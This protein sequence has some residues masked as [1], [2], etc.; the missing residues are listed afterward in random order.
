MNDKLYSMRVVLL[1]LIVLVFTASLNARAGEDY[2]LKGPHL[3]DV[4]QFKD[5]ARDSSQG[6]RLVPFKLHIPGKG[7]PYPVVVI[8]HGAGGNWDTHFAQAQ[9]LASHGFAVFCLEHVGSNTERMKRG[10]RIFH[11]LKQMIHSADEVLGRPKDVS[12][13]L[14]QITEWNKAH[15]SLKGRLDLGHVGVL[16]HSF[17]AF[18]AMVI[19]GMRPALNWLE[20]KV[21]TGLGPDL[22]DKRVRCGVALSPQAPGD[23]FFINESY[24]TLRV[25]LLGVSGT[26]DRQQNGEPPVSRL[27]SFKLWPSL[28]GNVFL[29]LNNAAHLDFTD[30]TGG[31]SHGISSPSRHNVQTVVRAASLMFFNRCLKGSP[32][33]LMELSNEHL[34]RYLSGAIN[35]IEIFKANH[36]PA[37][38]NK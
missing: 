14:D 23:P 2:S 4:I 36:Q 25:P 29:W 17:G 31:D 8:S 5:L 24:Q 20:P 18:T 12:F 26:K 3:V 38:L 30:T 19:A 21:G 6:R 1:F 9:H 22:F 13:V 27:E 10:I 16:G 37:L 32:S 35:R 11:H 7:G 33:S 28:K 34:E 15:P